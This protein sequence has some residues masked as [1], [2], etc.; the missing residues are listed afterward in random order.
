[1]DLLLFIPGILVTI[2]GLI[3]ILLRFCCDDM[4]FISWYMF[5]GGIILTIVGYISE[6]I[7]QVGCGC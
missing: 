1:M 5:I 7:T 6:P 3:F 2:T 4:V